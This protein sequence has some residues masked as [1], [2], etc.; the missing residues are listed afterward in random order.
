[1]NVRELEVE[2]AFTH[3]GGKNFLGGGQSASMAVE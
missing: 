1:M 2:P 3:P